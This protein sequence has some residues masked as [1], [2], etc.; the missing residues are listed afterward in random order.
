MKALLEDPSIVV[1]VNDVVEKSTEL[2]VD[3]LEKL[4]S[5]SDP[6]SALLEINELT[7]KL[8]AP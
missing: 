6:D 4:C 2:L 1:L 7:L 5:K 8:A 3:A